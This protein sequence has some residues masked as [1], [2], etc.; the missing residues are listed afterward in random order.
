[1]RWHADVCHYK[2]GLGF[3]VLED[4]FPGLD[5]DL[6]EQPVEV[7]I[8]TIQVNAHIISN[9]VRIAVNPRDNL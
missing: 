4:V 8:R 5:V 3:V 1:M 2:M 7:R 9:L 6:L